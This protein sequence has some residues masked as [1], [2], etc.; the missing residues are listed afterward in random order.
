[1]AAT[2]VLGRGRV[3]RHVLGLL[4]SAPGQELHTREIARR[5]K[6]DVHP[7]HRALELLSSQ[8]LVESRRLG[9]LRL[10]AVAPHNPLVPSLRD[11]LRRTTGPAEWLRKQLSRM[12]GVQLAFLF[13]SY[14]AGNDKPGSDIDLFVVGSPD[15][16]RLSKDVTSVSTET[17]REIEPVVWR[18]DELQAPT[19]DQ[20]RFLRRVLREPKIWLVGDERELERSRSPVGTAMVPGSSRQADRAGR[21]RSSKATGARRRQPQARKS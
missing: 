10:W 12:P 7:A 16:R 21:A 1:M 9:N 3:L 5:V 6:A 19:P 17:S 18:L 2:S 4:M 13:G 11:V 15:W 20:G 8:G 14:A